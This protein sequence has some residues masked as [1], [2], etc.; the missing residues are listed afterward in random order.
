MEVINYNYINYLRYLE[1]SNNDN[2]IDIITF[3]IL[4]FFIFLFIIFSI[5][6]F[7]NILKYII[8]NIKSGCFIY[9]YDYLMTTGVSIMFFL[10]YFIFLIIYIAPNILGIS[11]EN[12]I[13]RNKSLILNNKYDFL[14]ILNWCSYFLLTGIYFILMNNIILDI[15]YNIFLIIKMNKINSIQNDNI[16]EVYQICKEEKNSDIVNEKINKYLI[17]CIFIIDLIAFLF[18]GFYAKELNQKN[19]QTDKIIK[20][21]KENKFIFTIQKYTATL[22][23]L[24]VFCLIINIIITILSTYYKKK[25]LENNYYSENILVQKIYNSSIERI[26]FHRDFY[27][28]KTIIDF[29][30]NIPILLYFALK[31]LSAI[32]IMIGGFCIGCYMFFMGALILY[33]EKESKKTKLTPH[34]KKIFCLKNMN[35][36]FGQSIKKRVLEDLNFEYNEDEVKIMQELSMNIDYFNDDFT[37]S[38]SINNKNKKKYS[39]SLLK[40]LIK[41]EENLE[42]ENENYEINEK[43]FQL[44]NEENYFIMCKLIYLYFEQNQKFYKENEKGFDD[45]S[46]Y[47]KLDNNNLEK[48]NVEI[49][50]EEYLINIDKINQLS[51]INQKE[52]RTIL[53]VNSEVIFQSIEEKEYKNKFKIN[54]KIKEDFFLNEKENFHIESYYTE[55]LFLIFPFYQITIKDI[56]NSLN[57]SLNKKI[58]QNLIN[59]KEKNKKLNDEYNSFKYHSKN[60]FTYNLFLSFETY[61]KDELNIL[62]MKQF[63]LNYNTYL[64]KIIKNME[65]TFIPLIIGIFE[66]RVLNKTKIVILYRNPLLYSQF[67]KFKR[68]ISFFITETPEKIF[69]SFNEG[70]L[71]LK[72]I[73]I[74]DN[75]FL[76]QFDYNELVKNLNRDMDFI[77]NSSSNIFPII[78][79]F[80]GEEENDNNEIIIENF[81]NDFKDK[82]FSQ[83]LNNEVSIST[84]NIKK[85]T[86]NNSEI[87]SLFEKEY[88]CINQKNIYSIKIFFTNFFR[89]NCYLNEIEKKINNSFPVDA[90]IDYINDQIF[91]NYIKKQDSVIG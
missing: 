28:Y 49:N 2:K 58:Y 37:K 90:Y 29:V 12:Y 13:D 88:N 33:I 31:Q 40:P 87:F 46:F 56:L 85:K 73:E 82:S 83:I 67:N 7:T 24:Q 36:R 75:I 27:I 59:K 91:K 78:N 71:S 43:E 9:W 48:K 55:E 60:F 8:Q 68:W 32:P 18:Y 35:F 23:F 22:Q 52:L 76:N 79:I 89:N 15:M 38:I 39:N 50:N 69:D 72:E 4:F 19:I 86:E 81:E 1:K 14:K 84:I 64:M 47:K 25:L 34:I 51:K 74:N 63:I 66:I 57:P 21:I 16:Q 62:N 17:I 44:N 65:Y 61:E 70:L 53:K 42:N 41:K 5:Y 6:Y 45:L 80:I 10:F 77:K 11:K 26:S 54:N 3:Y 30:N 20:S